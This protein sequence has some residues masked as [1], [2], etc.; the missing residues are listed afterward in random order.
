MQTKNYIM[1]K[2]YKKKLT[3]LKKTSYI[4]RD[5]NLIISKI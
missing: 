5:Y 4:N 1:Q 3:T 2:L